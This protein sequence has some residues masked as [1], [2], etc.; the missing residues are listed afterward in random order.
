[1]KQPPQVVYPNPHD[2]LVVKLG[3][4]SSDPLAPLKS[5]LLEALTVPR[6]GEF[7]VGPTGE[8]D[9]QLNAFIRINASEFNNIMRVR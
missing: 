5:R 4:A 8:P 6:A 3:V 9:P 7:S 2:Y 1:M